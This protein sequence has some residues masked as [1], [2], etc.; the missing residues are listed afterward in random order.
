MTTWFKQFY[1]DSA[2]WHDVVTLVDFMLWG[3]PSVLYRSNEELR[4]L[5]NQALSNLEALQINGFQRWEG[6]S[7]DDVVR[8][9]TEQAL[10]AW[11]AR[12]EEF[13]L[14]ND[15][16]VLLASNIEGP[17]LDI[18]TEHPRFP[19]DESPLHM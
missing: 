15:D 14:N 3:L 2:E 13:L 9:P 19:N 17:W 12:L 4:T 18:Y 5:A 1:E 11:R 7:G 10:A 16:Y 6:I 8:I